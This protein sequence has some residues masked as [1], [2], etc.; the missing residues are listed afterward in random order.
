[1]FGRKIALLTALGLALHP[2]LVYF[3]AWIITDTF[4]L[5]LF[6]GTVLMALELVERPGAVV[7]IATGVCLGLSVL[8][9]PQS[10]LM[11]PL[12]LLWFLLNSRKTA[13]RVWLA[14]ALLLVTATIAV[15]IPWTLRNY[16]VHGEWIF[17]S[18]Q[19]GYTFHGANNPDAF[20]GHVPD[21][22][23]PIEGLSEVELDREYYRRGL[24]WIRSSPGDFLRLL[25]SKFARLWS[26]VQVNTYEGEDFLPYASLLKA[27]Y[28]LYLALA[29]YG[30]TQLGPRWGRSMILLFPIAVFTL[31]GLIY[32]G[33]TRYAL[34]TAPFIVILAAVGLVRNPLH[35]RFA[36]G[37]MA[38]FARRE[39][40]TMTQGSE[41]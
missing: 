17:V 39:S 13:L 2:L 22:P 15:L 40:E 37:R 28:W 29:A 4:F 26:P 30:A 1:L 8:T 21:Y 35:R 18:T 12:L 5:V 19:G 6:T 36:R 3:G 38:R 25:P 41:L 33:G 24:D 10:V 31:V 16:A 20:G 9:R 14:P 32:Y 11:L 23:P 34:P 7:A 27:V